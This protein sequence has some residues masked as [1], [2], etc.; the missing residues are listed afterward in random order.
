[1]NLVEKEIK[2]SKQRRI[3]R[4]ENNSEWQD[5]MSTLIESQRVKLKIASDKTPKEQK[6]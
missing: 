5:G 4:K 1:M 3:Y 6:I 2:I